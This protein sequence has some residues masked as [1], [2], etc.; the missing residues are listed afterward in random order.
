MP[1]SEHL[2]L[3]FPLNAM[4][5]SNMVTQILQVEVD[6]W[7]CQNHADIS[8]RDHYITKFMVTMWDVRVTLTVTSCRDSFFDHFF[9]FMRLSENI[10]QF[11]TKVSLYN[12][13]LS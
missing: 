6:G 13:F 7:F 5:A 12:I 2:F 10:K 8:Q 3:F 1:E 4:A 9:L 11:E